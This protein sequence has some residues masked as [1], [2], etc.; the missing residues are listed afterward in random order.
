[1]PIPCFIAIAS[2]EEEKRQKEHETKTKIHTNYPSILNLRGPINL[3]HRRYCKAKVAN[4]PM[5]ANPIPV[6]ILAALDFVDDP[7]P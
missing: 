2:K 7:P 1:M 4:T 5:T 6:L 3:D